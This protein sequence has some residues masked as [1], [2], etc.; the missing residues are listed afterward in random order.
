MHTEAWCVGPASMNR[1]PSLSIGT[2][3]SRRERKRGAAGVS[4]AATAGRRRAGVAWSRRGPAG[5]CRCDRIWIIGPVTCMGAVRFR[6]LSLSRRAWRQPGSA[7]SKSARAP[8][9]STPRLNPIGCCLDRTGLARRPDVAGTGRR[10]VL[11]HWGLRW[12]NAGRE[13]NPP[14]IRKH[15]KKNAAKSARLRCL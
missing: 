10:P 4:V 7:V 1:P 12:G 15:H 13:S 11:L 14:A 9:L 2:A 3:S 6:G 5:W 8:N